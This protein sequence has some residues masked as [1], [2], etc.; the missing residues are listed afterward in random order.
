M[1]SRS[2]LRPDQFTLRLLALGLL[3]AVPY[4]CALALSDLRRHT[5]AFEVIFG[6]AF[7]LYA[8][9]AWLALRE[10]RTPRPALAV[11]AAFALV[12]HGLLIFTAPTLSDDAYRY[13]WDGRVQARG[14]SPY[15]YPPDAPELR[16]LRDTEVWPSINRKDAVTVYPAGAELVYALLWRIGP[17]S[18]RWTQ[19]A[20]SAG[21]LLAGLILLPLLR[22]LGRPPH[23]VLI[24]WWSPLVAFETAHAAHVDGLVL[25]LLVGAWLARAR[26]RDLLVGVLLGAAAS[27]KLY[28]AL[29]LPA[30]WRPRDEAG[31]TAPAWSM[32]LA[33]AM[34]LAVTYVPYAAEGR[35]VIGFLP[36]YLQERFNMGLAAAITWLVEAAGGHPQTVVNALLI[37]AWAAI[38]VALLMRPAVDAEVAIRRCIWPIGAFTLLAQNLFPWY[39]L[40]LVPL[41]AVYVGRR[42]SAA[43]YGWFLF[44]GLVALAY[45]FF[46]DWRPV[47]WALAVQFLPLYGAL[48][49]DAWQGW[50][51][52][53]ATGTA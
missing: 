12:Y 44:T 49:W 14:I 28:P 27:V 39:M 22:A 4:A 48:L 53:R 36:L 42:R 41:L 7:V 40:W 19:V 35:A 45:T 1:R 24:Y 6:A 32:P 30:L 23:W 38:A 5:I 52:W 17:D 43:W 33:F 3:G 31:R 11:I 13:V 34:T 47:P 8:V 15:A 16:S 46:V 20:M 9:A 51:R 37:A 18:M 2:S 29:L 25:P 26:G 50:R 10:E 21:A